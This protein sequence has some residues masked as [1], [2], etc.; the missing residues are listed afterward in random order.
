MPQG[1]STTDERLLRPATVNPMQILS[2]AQYGNLSENLE[3]VFYFENKARMTEKK[4][5]A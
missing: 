5:V 2:F 1:F 4:F 3:C